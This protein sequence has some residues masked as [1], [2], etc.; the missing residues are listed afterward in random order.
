MKGNAITYR[1][2]IC[3]CTYALYIFILAQVSVSPLLKTLNMTTFIT[4]EDYASV[5]NHKLNIECVTEKPDTVVKGNRIVE[6]GYFTE[7]IIDL[8]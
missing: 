3:T 8:Q 2:F 4:E 6:I 5:M 7:R 1:Y